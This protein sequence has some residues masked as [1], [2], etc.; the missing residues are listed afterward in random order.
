[1]NDKLFSCYECGSPVMMM[2]IQGRTIEYHPGYR[3]PI[4][5][6]ILLPT[7]THCGEFYLD[8]ESAKKLDPILKREFLK[9]QAGHYKKLI[10]RLRDV[11]KVTQIDIVRACG[12]TAS[13]L[14]HILAGKRRASIT[15]TRLLEA[16]VKD[17]RE[18]RRHLD[19]RPWEDSLVFPPLRSTSRMMSWDKDPKK[20]FSNSTWNVDRRSDS[21][22]DCSANGQIAA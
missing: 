13:H 21:V 10:E 7:C 3:V 22:R 20:S 12:I 18:F 16:F 8:E 17:G 1:M 9:Q 4:P 14:S 5:A 15:L 19:G 6:D 2:A 11:H